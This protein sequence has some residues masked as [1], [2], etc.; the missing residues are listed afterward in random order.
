M[1]KETIS[2]ENESGLHARPASILVKEASKYTSEIKLIKDENEYNP[3]S[4][5]S[6]LTMGGSKGDHIII[7]AEGEDEEEAVKGLIETIKALK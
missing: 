6:I 4:I 1:Y 2:L 5:M 7:E 3:K